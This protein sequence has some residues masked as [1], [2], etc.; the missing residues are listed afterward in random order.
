[1]PGN[2]VAQGSTRMEHFGMDYL[3]CNSLESALVLGKPLKLED[4]DPL[5]RSLRLI[6][7][8]NSLRLDPHCA[9]KDLIVPSYPRMVLHRESLTLRLGLLRS[10]ILDHESGE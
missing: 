3:C 9:H 1:M 8:E 4:Y 10:I 2:F 5:P 7:T 6:L